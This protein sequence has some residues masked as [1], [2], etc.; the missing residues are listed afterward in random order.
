MQARSSPGPGVD[1]RL[2]LVPGLRPLDARRPARALRR[3][4]ARLGRDASTRDAAGRDRRPRPLPPRDLPGGARRHRPR[5]ARRLPADPGVVGRGARRRHGPARHR[6]VAA[7]DLVA[8]RAP[9]RRRRDRGPR[10]RGERGRPP[11]RRRPPRSV[12]AARLAP[13]ARRRRRRSPRSRTA[14]PPRRRRLRRCSPTSAAPTWATPRSSRSSASSTAAAPGC[15]STR[16]RRR[17]GSTRRSAG[18]GPMLE[19]LF[20]TTRAVV[21]LVLNGTVAAP[22]RTSSSSSRTPAR[23][24]PMVADRVAAFS[25]L[26]G[27]STRRSTCCATS[28]GST[29]T[30]PASRPAP[31]R[32]AAH[33]HDARPPALRQRLPVHARSSPSRWPRERLDEA[34]DPPARSTCLRANTERLFPP[35]TGRRLTTD[36]SRGPDMQH[37]TRARLPRPRGARPDALTP[38]LADVVGLVPGEPTPSGAATWRDDDRAH[39]LVVA[40]GDRRTTPLR[41][42]VRGGRRRRVRRHRR[43]APSDRAP[44]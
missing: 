24:S 23:R 26:L 17:A 41:V 7:V 12:R 27:T 20:D 31:A 5:P 16:P 11:G 42:G 36:P 8:R 1:G 9:R 43:A 2:P 15:S 28:A 25:L 34:G 39:R 4:P 18:P 32:R 40:A 44:R 10:P 21:D 3:D 38:V 19:F 30:S 6:D 35:L 29:S 13:A 14:R 22:P 33:A 37:Q